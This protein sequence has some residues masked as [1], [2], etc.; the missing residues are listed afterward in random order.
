MNED[1]NSFDGITEVHREAERLLGLRSWL[2]L[3]CY[4]LVTN[5][6]YAGSYV[7]LRPIAEQIELV[8]QLARGETVPVHLMH[9]HAF[10]NEEVSSLRWTRDGLVMVFRDREVPALQDEAQQVRTD[11]MSESDALHQPTAV[12]EGADLYIHLSNGA[13]LNFDAWPVA[14]GWEA[15]ATLQREGE[16]LVVR[17]AGPFLGAA[18]AKAAALVSLSE[19]LGESVPLAHLLWESIEARRS[20]LRASQDK[21]PGSW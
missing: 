4:G 12:D 18:E 15:M 14:A 21:S 2:L 1:D 9:R 6:P 5:G 19:K 7:G 3:S 20:G 8:H 13:W 10:G 16:D 17:V 11:A